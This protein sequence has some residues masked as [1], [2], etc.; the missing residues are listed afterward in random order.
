MEEFVIGVLVGAGLTSVIF[1]VWD[2]KVW[3]GVYGLID[4]RNYIQAQ[5][6]EI[7]KRQFSLIVLWLKAVKE[8]KKD[9]NFEE[10]IRQ[11]HRE[12]KELEITLKVLKKVCKLFGIEEK[13]NG[14]EE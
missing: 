10:K 1:F 5:I 2:S 12:K 6:K 9:I 3:L 11:M 14:G 7:N 4:Y 13:N 8:E